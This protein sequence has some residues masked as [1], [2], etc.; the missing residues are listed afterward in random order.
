MAEREQRDSRISVMVRSQYRE[1]FVVA[2]F[3][4]QLHAPRVERIEYGRMDR[5]LHHAHAPQVVFEIDR[6]QQRIEP[7]PD[8]FILLRI[9]ASQGRFA[10]VGILLRTEQRKDRLAVR[11]TVR[12]GDQAP[13]LR[14]V[15]AYGAHGDQRIDLPPETLAQTPFERQ[16]TLA[17]QTLVERERSFR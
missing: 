14:P 3:V 1:G 10:P 2:P 16:G 9:P 15:L 13:Q 6:A 4:E 11:Q 17:R 5:I 7:L 8:I 12:G